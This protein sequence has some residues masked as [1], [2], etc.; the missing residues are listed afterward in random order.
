M[1]SSP[2]P[3]SV[4]TAA[5]LLESIRQ[6]RA[7]GKPTKA[8]NRAVHE[9]VSKQLAQ[10]GLLDHD[11]VLGTL[12]AY[13]ITNLTLKEQ[14]EVLDA[15]ESELTLLA[16]SQRLTPIVESITEPES[17]PTTVPT[18]AVPTYNEDEDEAEEPKLIH[19]P[20]LPEIKTYS[21]EEVER[22]INAFEY[23]PVPTD[24]TLPL[25]LH[26]F[27]A[28]CWEPCFDVVQC[29]LIIAPSEDAGKT[30]LI[31]V[32]ANLSW[33]GMIKGRITPAKLCDEIDEKR[34]SLFIDEFGV[35][36]KWRDEDMDIFHLGTDRETGRKEIKNDKDGRGVRNIFCPKTF[37]RVGMMNDAMLVS[38]GIATLLT[39]IPAKMVYEAR[40][41]K[42]TVRRQWKS[43]RDKPLAQQF[44]EPIHHFM[45][46]KLDEIHHVFQNV[47]N[48]PLIIDQPLLVS[49]ELQNWAPL[50]P[51]CKVAFPHRLREL[52]VIANKLTLQKRCL[53]DQVGYVITPKDRRRQLDNDV[54]Q[55]IL[56]ALPPIFEA[57]GW[58]HH[59][60]VFMRFF[61]WFPLVIE[62][63][64]ELSGYK[65][66][67]GVLFDIDSVKFYNEDYAKGVKRSS[68]Y[69]DA[70]N[71]VAA[72]V[73][74]LL[75]IYKD[76]R[77]TE[78]KVRGNNET[79]YL[80]EPILKA[81]AELGLLTR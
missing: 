57:K 30:T 54:A 50:I 80:L 66:A 31:K 27:Q 4:A 73:A 52:L 65:D 29:L 20:Q 78:K 19:E 61:D 56:L 63:L 53:P 44:R 76:V 7:Q 58:R 45:H 41:R 47:E 1:E 48:D 36:S 26:V 51:I 40:M 42:A 77:S 49:R 13:N 46:G 64:P 25:A 39:K 17:V 14:G 35:F 69:Y 11:T 79:V 68:P 32:M 5:E 15:I 43:D 10:M 55:M 12:S 38:R 75:S 67:G 28:S 23:F 59:G 74:S 70:A 9:W 8:S 34:P 22:F 33:Q 71:K 21:L 60:E 37:G 24:Y 3:E 81:I 62:R 2:T 6:Q 16:Q 18:T 72:K